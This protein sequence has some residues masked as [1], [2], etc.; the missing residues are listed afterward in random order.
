MAEERKHPKPVRFGGNPGTGVKEPEYMNDSYPPG[1]RPE[2]GITTSMKEER[3]R[4]VGETRG[5]RGQCYK[6]DCTW[7][8]QYL[9]FGTNNIPDIETN[10]GSER[11]KREKGKNTPFSDCRP[12][13]S[14]RDQGLEDN[15]LLSD[16]SG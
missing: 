2:A 14:L 15:C 13:T 10:I 16:L 8:H 12:L 3:L 1:I 4:L 7:E 5:A 9:R 6:P 11:S